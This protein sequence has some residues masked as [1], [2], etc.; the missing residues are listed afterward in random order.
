MCY[1]AQPVVAMFNSNGE[2]LSCYENWGSGWSTEFATVA[3]SQNSG[4]LLLVDQTKNK[5]YESHLDQTLVT[6]ATS[7]VE[8]HY[9]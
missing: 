7:L 4:G 2:L 1:T 9:V 5:L 8:T 6:Y 3:I